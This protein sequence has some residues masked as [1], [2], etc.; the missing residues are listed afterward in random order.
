[1]SD[2]INQQQG[3]QRLQVELSAL[4]EKRK[5]QIVALCG[6]QQTARLVTSA[7]IAAAENERIAQCDPR[8]I[9]RSIAQAAML[10]IDLANGLGEGWLVPFKGKCTLM[11]GYRGWERRAQAEGFRILADVVYSGD[12]FK[13]SQV[14]KHVEHEPMLTGTRG[15]FLGAYAVAYREGSNEIYDATWVYADEIKKSMDLAL[16]RMDNP[17]ASPWNTW[18]DRMRRKLAIAR[19]CKDLPFA[20]PVAKKLIQV[21]ADAERGGG[22]D[23]DL[24]DIDGIVDQGQLP[25]NE[26]AALPAAQSKTTELLE[27][28]RP[29]RPR[30]EPVPIPATPAMPDAITNNDH[31]TD[32]QWLLDNREPGAEG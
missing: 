20:S 4:L 32:N 12:R 25:R 24:D 16:S 14:P 6:N 19:L 17:G 10:E 11:P 26:L 8:S 23:P 13:F 3:L 21:D 27:K 18:P 30:K 31:F 5:A 28:R 7:M 29:G 22:F 1:M 9:L 15:D 2:K